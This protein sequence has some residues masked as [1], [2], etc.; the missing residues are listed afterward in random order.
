MSKR[1]AAVASRSSWLG[2]CQRYLLPVWITTVCRTNRVMTKQ[3]LFKL[4]TGHTHECVIDLKLQIR[5]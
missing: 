3:G 4:A 1:D 2:T 5:E